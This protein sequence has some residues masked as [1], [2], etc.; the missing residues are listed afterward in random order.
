MGDF[1]KLVSIWKLYRREMGQAG[2]RRKSESSP[3][4][5]GLGGNVRND[6]PSDNRRNFAYN[7]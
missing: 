3:V 6:Q 1:G 2:N 4:G 5:A 7:P